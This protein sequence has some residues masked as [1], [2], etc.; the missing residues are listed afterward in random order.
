MGEG[1]PP[2]IP[3]LPDLVV[4]HED[5]ALVT[6]MEGEFLWLDA[7]MQPTG[8]VTTPYPMRVR[9]AS[10]TNGHLYATWLDRELLMA[11]MACLPVGTENN[12]PS[13]AE[14][15][16]SIGAPMT[17]HPAGNGWAHSL[18]AEP[19][20][21]RA[22]ADGV[23]FVLYR[24]GIY[25]IGLDAN[26]HWRMASPTWTYPKKR[27]RNEEI[28][29]LHLDGDAFLVVSKGGR[30]QVRSLDNGQLTEEYVLEGIEGPVEHHFLH[31]IHHLACSTDGELVWVQDGQPIR[32][33]QLSGPV[34]H[35]TWDEALTGWRIAGWREEIVLAHDRVE[36]RET[37]E[38]PVHVHPMG[39]HSL[40]LYND[41]TWEQSPIGG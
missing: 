2:D 19:M 33:V 25:S 11:C 30:I 3:F 14:L 17:H 1:L 26:E 32:R 10:I 20:A 15:R 21:L 38:I 22:N 23:V 16:T 27:P 35:A 34:Q 41:G 40:L 5:G 36:R 18:D 8:S 39:N 4:H 13:R 29:A 12:G 9:Q 28:I 24:R 37:R 7:N 6:G 31:G